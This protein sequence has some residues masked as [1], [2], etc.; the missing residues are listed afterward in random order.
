MTEKQNPDCASWL[1]SKIEIRMRVKRDKWK[2]M[3]DDPDSAAAVK[4][5]LEAPDREMIIFYMVESKDEL[6]AS[7][8]LDQVLSSKKAVQC[9]RWK[10][11]VALT[12]QNI[13][14]NVTFL[15]IAGGGRQTIAQLAIIIDEVYAP[16]L[17][18]PQV[19]V[20]W[21]HVVVA[22]VARSLTRYRG[23]VT[24]AVAQ[25][26][27]CAALMPL[28]PV[29]ST[30]LSTQH[31]K[32]ALHSLETALGDWARQVQGIILDTPPRC[33]FVGGDGRGPMDEVAFWER[34]VADSVDLEAV[35]QNA[36]ARHIEDIL[37]KCGSHFTGVLEQVMQG[38]LHTLTEARE[39]LRYMQPLRPYFHELASCKLGPKDPNGSLLHSLSV[40]IIYGIGLLSRHARGYG[41]SPLRVATLLRT[42][43]NDVVRNAWAALDAGTLLVVEH[44]EAVARCDAA[45][46]ILHGFRR[47]YLDMKARGGIGPWGAP[48]KL[49]VAP[50]GGVSA[51]KAGL[52]DALVGTGAK[53][54]LKPH[55]GKKP[56]SPLAEN[57]SG[58]GAGN[59]V[60]V[61]PPPPGAT[62]AVHDDSVVLSDVDGMVERV[63]RVADAVASIQRFSPVDNLTMGGTVS[64]RY[65]TI[66]AAVAEE[67]GAAQQQLGGQLAELPDGAGRGMADR[68]AKADAALLA[69]RTNMERLEGQLANVL[70]H[71]F[72]EMPTLQL[73]AT[74]HAR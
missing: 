20:N 29:E 1:A 58:G 27:G 4:A 53:S 34:K 61:G 25:A 68:E 56:K 70:T 66:I 2:R 35:L 16:L 69:F 13:A 22:D 74:T 3:M 38:T 21:P 17:R 42:V 51:K 67:F 55:E 40:R 45:R 10:P 41:A 32:A 30:L 18:R 47:A 31:D 48:P 5:F 6:V 39:I 71:A 72:A 12:L 62:L 14:A 64:A 15:E 44:D 73:P 11:G 8:Q 46:G 52:W 37:R 33:H 24:A 65:G 28:P 63:E 7:L 9:I 19:Q 26:S 23:A 50:T 57:P 59:D 49:A 60:V 54:P 43:A 36:A